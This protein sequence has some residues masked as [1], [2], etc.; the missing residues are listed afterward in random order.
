[1]KTADIEDKGNIIII[2]IPDSKTRKV[3]I[4][5]IIGENNLNMYGIFPMYCICEVSFST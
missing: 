1:M 2:N 4:F 5:I 3:R